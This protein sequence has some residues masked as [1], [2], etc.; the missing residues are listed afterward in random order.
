MEE[1]KLNLFYFNH[2]IISPIVFFIIEITN[3][4]QEKF[5][6]NHTNYL[7]KILIDNKLADSSNILIFSVIK[8]HSEKMINW[9][10]PSKECN[11]KILKQIEKDAN[12]INIII[13]KIIKNSNCETLLIFSD[14]ELKIQ[15]CNINLNYLCELY[16][17]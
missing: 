1:H 9:I 15:D 5:I 11:S 3:D 10:L 4:K 7:F 13:N 8:K 6:E 2:K 17:N 16:K 14:N 12:L